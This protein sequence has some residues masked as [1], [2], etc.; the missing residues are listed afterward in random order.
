MDTFTDVLSF[1]V[2]LL[3]ILVAI[4]IG[5]FIPLFLFPL[6]PGA[7]A[8]LANN[9]NRF[10]PEKNPSVR[11]YEPSTFGFFTTLAPGQV[12]LIERG[13]RFIGGIMRFEGH[14]FAGEQDKKLA[15]NTHGYWEVTKTNGDGEDTHPIPKPSWEKAKKD[16]VIGVLLYPVK[17]I[18]WKWKRWVY[19]LTG[20][21][22]TGFYPFQQVRVETIDRYK[23]IKHADGSEEIV[24][25]ADY[26]DHFRVAD[27]QFPVIIPDADTQDKIPVRMIV[28]TVM[29]CFNPYLA[30]YAT[31][32]W[33]S[34]ST[35][36]IGDAV[37]HYTRPRKLDVVLSAESTGD[38]RKMGEEISQIGNRTIPEETQT[39]NNI[40][41]FGFEVR[42][43][44]IPDISLANKADARRLGDVAFARVDRDAQVIRSE[45][46]AQG[47]ALQAKAV[48]EGGAAGMAVLLSE[49]NI[50]TADVAGDKA[51]VVIGG[52]ADPFAA[53]TFKEIK[54]INDNTKGT[55]DG[56]T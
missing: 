2:T 30:A 16:G 51:I 48:T 21:V 19:E 42:Q 34:R 29:R 17:W 14:S 54:Q 5:V 1:I 27:F 38:V 22:F 6:I 43:V 12:K 49:R 41:A 15:R 53:A 45:G 8:S 56:N 40:V 32:D 4:P 36:S 28:D 50:K 3:T 7:V 31:D 46:T 55:S 9:P 20:Y 24:Y 26:T 47:I 37:T 11:N 25:I 10:Q 44:L 35:T 39:P 23:K 52:G 18:W 33:S 13:K